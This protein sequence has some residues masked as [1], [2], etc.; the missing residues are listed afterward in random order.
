MAGK[1]NNE[2]GETLHIYK[3]RPPSPPSNGST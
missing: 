2:P 1:L 3:C